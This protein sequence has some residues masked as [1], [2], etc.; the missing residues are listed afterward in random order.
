[1]EIKLKRVVLKLKKLKF[2][3]EKK[4]KKKIVRGKDFN[5]E[6]YLEYIVDLLKNEW[7]TVF[8]FFQGVN[9]FKNLLAKR[10]RF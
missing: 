1:M 6:G 9:I 5:N 3:G 8:F 10:K 7:N 4:K 2:K